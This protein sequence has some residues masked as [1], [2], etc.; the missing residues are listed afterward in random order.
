MPPPAWRK[1]T[2]GAQHTGNEAGF[3]AQKY[4]RHNYTGFASVLL[5]MKEPIRIQAAG[6]AGSLSPPPAPTHCQEGG[7]GR[8]VCK[9]LWVESWA[10]VPL[11]EKRCLN[12]SRLVSGAETQTLQTAKI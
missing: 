3:V 11:E 8:D 6:A 2:Q 1:L 4:N 9:N 12:H 5:L 10:L 7:G